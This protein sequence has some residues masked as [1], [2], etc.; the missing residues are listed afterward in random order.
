M[1][2]PAPWDRAKAKLK[3]KKP[4]GEGEEERGEKW[5]GGRGGGKDSKYRLAS[6]SPR[7]GLEGVAARDW[8]PREAGI[9]G[10]PSRRSYAQRGRGRVGGEWEGEV[11]GGMGGG[12]WKI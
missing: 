5:G 12:L 6:A 8:R 9:V 10:I 1:R 4:W 11:L 7:A 3:K 2:V